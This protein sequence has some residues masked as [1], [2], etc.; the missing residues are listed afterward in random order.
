MIL[1]LPIKIGLTISAVFILGGATM[2][3][4][5][6]IKGPTLANRVVALDYLTALSISVIALFALYFNYP[7]FLDIAIVLALLS[8]LAVIAFARF[9]EHRLRH[10]ILRE[11]LDD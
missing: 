3:F 2:S 11:D 5:R 1:S 8:F 10:G 9:I 4:I 6:M 7:D